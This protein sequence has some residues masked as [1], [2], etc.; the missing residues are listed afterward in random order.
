MQLNYQDFLYYLNRYKTV[1]YEYAR[2]DLYPYRDQF[3]TAF[4]NGRP[5]NPEKDKD[6]LFNT[7]ITGV[8]ENR[9]AYI[10]K[11]YATNDIGG[12]FTRDCADELVRK[13]KEAF[14]LK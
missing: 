7:L 9:L 3:L 5:I 4:Y 2:V 13:T 1:A 6:E 11:K 14:G 12:K 10:T 8:F